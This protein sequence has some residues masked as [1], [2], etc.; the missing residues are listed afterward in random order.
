[1]LA[2]VA[3][4]LFP[5]SPAYLIGVLLVALLHWLLP[6]SWRA[7][8]LLCLSLAHAA[9]LSGWGLSLLALLILFAHRRAA[10][11]R[12]SGLSF[13]LMLLLGAFVLLKAPLLLSA[14]IQRELP[15][16]VPLA[17]AD[18]GALVLPLGLSYCLFR[19]IH[20]VV[21]VKR[22]T[23]EPVPLHRLGL[24]VLWFPTLRAGPIERL[25]RFTPQVRPAAAE[26]NGGLLRTVSGVLKKTLVADFLLRGLLGP[27]LTQ[28]ALPWPL[29]SLLRWYTVT[30]VVYMDFSGYS[31]LAIGQSR[32]LGYRIVENFD[33]PLLK[34]NIA[35]FW[36]SWHISLHLFIRDYFFFPLFGRATSVRKMYAGLFLA[37]VCSQIWHALTI[38]FLLLGAY[39]GLLLVLYAA[40]ERW[41]RPRRKGGPPGLLARGLGALGTFQLAAAGFWIFFWG[42]APW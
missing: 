41:R 5:A 9:L 20:Y 16:F 18:P 3:P 42:R 36:R 38:N 2:A 8:F 30:L 33:Y 21:E 37:F 35:A 32:L 13:S 10:P 23:Q 4:H 25:P 6:R 14:L 11:G 24:Y 22:G 17:A 12:G 27:W 34:P 31:D 29:L 28:A 19:L 40:W 26:I 7:P 15:V 1:M 39:H